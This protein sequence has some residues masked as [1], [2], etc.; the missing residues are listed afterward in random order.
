VRARGSLNVP[1]RPVLPL[2][3]D[4]I[5]IVHI[6]LDGESDP[7]WYIPLL[8]DGERLRAGRMVR[9][10]DRG[11]F[12]VAH[13]VT[14]EALAYCI[15]LDPRNIRFAHGSHGKP[16]LAGSPADVRFSLTHSGDQALL[17]IA[18][19]RE[20]GVDIEKECNLDVCELA[21]HVFSPREI[22]SLEAL[23]QDDRHRGFF[24]AWTRKESFVKA[25]GDGL[26]FPL[27]AFDVSVDENPPQALLAWPTAPEAF[28]RWSIRPVLVERGY[29]AAMTVEGTQWRAI[30]WNHPDLT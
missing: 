1:F 20:V 30:H 2:L 25:L 22:D 9:D 6:R 7:R 27:Q 21:H 13:G 24:R 18:A 23:P 5:H 15:G 29:Q 16:R 17:A 3:H 14:R 28:E 4:E 11:R 8:D 26:S 19:G 12:V 10:R